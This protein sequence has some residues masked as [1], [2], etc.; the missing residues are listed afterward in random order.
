MTE[1]EVIATINQKQSELEEKKAANAGGDVIKDLEMEIA[2]L[3]AELQARNEA[4]SSEKQVFLD[5]CAG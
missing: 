3:A 5:E 1:A 4:S 2:E